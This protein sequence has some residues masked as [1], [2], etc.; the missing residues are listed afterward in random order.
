MPESDFREPPT[1]AAGGHASAST[2]ERRIEDL[3]RSREQRRRQLPRAVAVGVAA[4]LIAV[5]FRWSLYWAEWWRDALVIWGHARGPVW[6]VLPLAVSIAGAVLSVLVVRRWA[7][8]AAGSGIPHLKAVLDHLRQL[9]G[10]RVLPVKFVGGLLAM[11]SGLSLGREGPTVQMGGA[12]GQIVGRWLR[13]TTRERRTLVAAGAGAGLSAAFNAPLAGLVFVL[14]EVQR[15]F[16]ANV[17][18]ATLAASVAADIVARLFLGQ[19]PVFHVQIDAIPELNL[20][21]LASVVG[22]VAAFFGIAFNR[23]L[24]ASLDGF[25]WLRARASWAPAA[26]AGLL[27]GVVLWFAPTLVGTGRVLMDDMLT[28]NIGLFALAGIF[29]VR[30][31]L[32]LAAYGCGAPGGI[33]APMLIL[34][35]ALGLAIAD[36]TGTMVALSA[37]DIRA[38]AVVGMAA[39][40]SAVVRAPLTGIVLMVEMTGQYALVLPLVLASAIAYGVA[41]FLRDPPIYHSLLERELRAAREPQRLAEPMLLQLSIA[42]GAPYDGRRVRDLALPPGCLVISIQRNGLNHVPT[43]DAVVA[44]GD[45]MH[46][47]VAPDASAAVTALRSGAGDG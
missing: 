37:N 14:E 16:G 45:R 46:V 39:Y 47:L 20:L 44:A 9:A 3:M 5:A 11:G 24:L 43:A 17:F 4:G 19:T 36:G 2:T 7:P 25:D 41:E 30:F 38:V 29:A 1:S 42:G 26:V 33:F 15:D 22:L 18:A 23:G 8:E 12:V 35:A 40:F 6:I 21:P 32:V 10:P 28:G 13:C 31:A 27:T 34:G